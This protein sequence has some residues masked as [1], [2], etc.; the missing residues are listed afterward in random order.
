MAIFITRQKKMD[1]SYRKVEAM[2][3]KGLSTDEIAKA[4]NLDRMD[5]L[6][7][8]QKIYHLDVRARKFN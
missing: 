2:Y 1:D 3:R 4:V 7:I 5:V 8:E 6:D